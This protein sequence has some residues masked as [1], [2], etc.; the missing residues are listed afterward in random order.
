MSLSI[1]D[2]TVRY[3]DTVAVDGVSL[4]VADG[5]VVALLG[6]SGCGK[7]TLL[8]AV[9]GLEAPAG[10]RI[11][12]GETDLATVAVHRRGFGLMFQDGVLFGHRTVGGNIGY[13]LRRSGLSRAGIDQRVTELLELVGLPGTARRSVGSLSGGQAQRVALARA[14]APHPRLLLLDEPLAALDKLLRDR[15][16]AD[17]RGVL[18]GTGS[19]ALYVTHDQGEAFALADRV[20][21]MADGRIRQTG[22]PQQVWRE[23]ADPFVAEFVGFTGR[24]RVGDLRAAGVAGFG[25]RPDDTGVVLRPGALRIDPDGPLRAQVRTVVPAVDGARLSV[26]LP[27]V[28]P[29]DAL[30]DNGLP[31]PAVGDTVSLRFD[32]VATAVL[33]DQAGAEQGAGVL[34]C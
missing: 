24:A 34:A 5:E 21:V 7:S 23:P 1:E 19:T 11:R 30:L 16:L 28:G 14:L 32:P 33:A 13:G 3:G 25:D 22:A 27:V 9:A 15:L 29:L 17:L 20:A 2:L 26:Q 18:A 6:P 8:R 31:V 12:W 4:D 10:G